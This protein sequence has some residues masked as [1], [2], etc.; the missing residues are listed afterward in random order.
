MLGK[1]SDLIRFVRECFIRGFSKS[2]FLTDAYFFFHS[3]Q[4]LWFSTRIEESEMKYRATVEDYV[5]M[6][7]DFEEFEEGKFSIVINNFFLSFP[8]VLI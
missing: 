7:E 5:E 6:E 4:F 3:V 8:K 1:V 2:F